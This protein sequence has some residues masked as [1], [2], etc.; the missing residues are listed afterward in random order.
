MNCYQSMILIT[1]V[2]FFFCLTLKIQL[3]LM[4][5]GGQ[6]I[7]GGKLGTHSQVLVDYFQVLTCPCLFLFCFDLRTYILVHHVK[8]DKP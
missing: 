6:V 7:Y 4:K 1:S 2:P 8:Y 5:R 3:L